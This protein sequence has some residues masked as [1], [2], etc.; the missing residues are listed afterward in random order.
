LRL[1]SLPLLQESSFSAGI[2]NV[3]LVRSSAEKGF[4]VFTVTGNRMV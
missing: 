1:F 2:V 3:K 4:A